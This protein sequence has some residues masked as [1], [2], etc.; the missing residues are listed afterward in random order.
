MRPI[1][2]SGYEG[3][4]ANVVKLA[5]WG[6]VLVLAGYIFWATMQPPTRR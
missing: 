2:I 6:G 3:T 4:R 5:A 1:A